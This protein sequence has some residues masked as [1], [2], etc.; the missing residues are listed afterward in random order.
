MLPV[1]TIVRPGQIAV[2]LFVGQ[3]VRARRLSYTV[4]IGFVMSLPAC[5]AASMPAVFPGPIYAEAFKR[6]GFSALEASLLVSPRIR[7]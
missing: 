6:L 7:G 4:L 3:V 2:P 5:F 1:G